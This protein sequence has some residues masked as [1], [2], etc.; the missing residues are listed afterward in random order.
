ML[1]RGEAVRLPGGQV[2]GGVNR[3]ATDLD[4][5]LIDG[6]QYPGHFENIENITLR[7]VVAYGSRFAGGIIL[8]ERVKR[9]N[10]VN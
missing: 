5:L 10:E 8:R 7:N 2:V 9:P 6:G 4:A 1:T 3:H